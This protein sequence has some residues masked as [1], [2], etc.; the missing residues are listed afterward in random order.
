MVSCLAFHEVDDAPDKKVGVREALRVLE[1]KGQLVFV[2]LF[3]DPTRFGGLDEVLGAITDTDGLVETFR[4]ISELLEIPWPLNHARSLRYAV[5]I[6]GG[7][8]PLRANAESPDVPG[9]LGRT[10]RT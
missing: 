7:K 8:Q 9:M 5:L 6:A 1:P 10:A 2:D 3:D 4:P